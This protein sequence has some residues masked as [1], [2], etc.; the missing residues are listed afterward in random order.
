MA[1]AAPGMVSTGCERH[2][3]TNITMGKCLDR[4]SQVRANPT[5]PHR[6]GGSNGRAPGAD[7][8]K[9]VA[10]APRKPAAHP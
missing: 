3:R 10:V 2:G 9:G 8:I 4:H 5:R 1:G 7:T 6:T